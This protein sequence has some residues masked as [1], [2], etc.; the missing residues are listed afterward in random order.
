MTMRTRK[1]GSHRRL[2]RFEVGV[3]LP[4]GDLLLIVLPL[5]LLRLDETFQEVDT[6]RIPHHVVLSQVAERLGEG[7]GQLA[8]LVAGERFRV[9]GV[10]IFL[11]RRGQW[12][13]LAGFPEGGGEAWRG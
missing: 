2:V 8:E 6:Q 4:A 11:D 3:E 1:R 7:A 9:E 12:Q 10:E 13:L 5:H